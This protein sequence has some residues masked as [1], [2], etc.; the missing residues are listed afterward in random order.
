MERV[1][2]CGCK[3]CDC[4]ISCG[5]PV[6]YICQYASIVSDQSVRSTGAEVQLLLSP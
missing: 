4:V 2:G 1:G 3:T 5:L 6:F